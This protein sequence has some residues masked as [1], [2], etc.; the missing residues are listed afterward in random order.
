MGETINFVDITKGFR[1]LGN[2]PAFSDEVFSSYAEAQRYASNGALGLSNAFCGQLVRVLPES[3]DDDPVVY[4]IDNKYKLV[5]TTE[6][7]ATDSKLSF[8]FEYGSSNNITA[9]TIIVPAGFI[10]NTV[11]I[12]F[13]QGFVNDNAILLYAQKANLALDETPNVQY[14]VASGTDPILESRYG[15][16]NIIVTDEDES[17]FA[18]QTTITFNEKTA[19]ILLVNPDQ[20]DITHRGRGI[21]KLN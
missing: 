14:I 19:I 21:L 1:R 12:K 6:S 13:T 15:I 8:P 18:I 20:N 2:F 10:L 17:E 16:N 7:I 9:T 5:T 4:I 3:S 11:T